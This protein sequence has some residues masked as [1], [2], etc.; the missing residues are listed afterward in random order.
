MGAKEKG[1]F[2]GRALPSLLYRVAAMKARGAAPANLPD[3]GNIL[4][5]FKYS[6]GNKSVLIFTT[7]A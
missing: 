3:S 2:H 1:I 4:I 6:I 7:P 5:I